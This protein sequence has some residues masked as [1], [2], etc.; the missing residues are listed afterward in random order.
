MSAQKE[1]VLGWVRPVR[2]TEDRVIYEF[3]TPRRALRGAFYLAAAVGLVAGSFRIGADRASLAVW[4]VAVVPVVFATVLASWGLLDLV[5]RGLFE[6][7]VDRRA[8]TL[9]LSMPRERGEELAKVGFG[10]IGSVSLVERRP[11]PGTSGRVRYSVL[12]AVRD[13][14]RIGLGL[15]EDPA[16]AERLAA[17]FGELLGVGVTRSVHESRT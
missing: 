9:A 13:G 1:S 10:D 14:R 3:R 15:L 17:A 4:L 2:R 11:L 5:T 7:E 6:I 16:E 8:R 12:L